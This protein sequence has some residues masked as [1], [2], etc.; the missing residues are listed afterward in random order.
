M[1]YEFATG[2]AIEV[3]PEYCITRRV[4]SGFSAHQW[5]V[6][7]VEHFDGHSRFTLE[8]QPDFWSD[9]R[10]GLR[11]TVTLDSGRKLL[12]GMPVREL[13]YGEPGR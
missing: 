1:T 10:A 4:G 6:L 12:Y 7:D 2:R 11:R 9:D 13:L 3:E 5:T 8:L